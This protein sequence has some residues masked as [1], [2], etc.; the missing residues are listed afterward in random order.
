M[1]AT[2]FLALVGVG[3]A[4]AGGVLCSTQT[5]PCTSKWP[6]GTKLTFSNTASSV[7]T[8]TTG[9]LLETCTGSI[10][11]GSLTANPDANG[12]ATGTN[13]E[14]TW[15]GCTHTENTIILGS[16]RIQNIAGTYNGTV[17]ADAEMAGTLAGLFPGE[18]CVYGVS[19]GTPLGTLTE[20]NPATMDANAITRK[21]EPAGDTC[22]LGPETLKWTTTYVLTSPSGTTLAVSPS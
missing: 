7:T 1:A 14:A 3:S 6:L 20:G 5:T 10:A 4:S 13:E 11:K 16:I 2:A 17:V 12:E 9:T 18:N 8:T 15:A 19:A 21:R 22:F